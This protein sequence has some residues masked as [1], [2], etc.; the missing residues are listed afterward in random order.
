MGE[1]GPR[2]FLSAKDVLNQGVSL[3]V[4]VPGLSG[5]FCPLTHVKQSLP[6]PIPPPPLVGHLGVRGRQ[7]VCEPGAAAGSVYFRWWG[8]VVLAKSP[9]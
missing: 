3:V 4:C 7:G 2:F 9:A 1:P 6:R 5:R 8:K